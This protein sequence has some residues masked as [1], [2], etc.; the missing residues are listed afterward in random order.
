MRGPSHIFSPTPLFLLRCVHFREWIKN[1]AASSPAAAA[2]TALVSTG[3]AGSAIAADLEDLSASDK[4]SPEDQKAAE[5]E[6]IKRKL[7]AQAASKGQMGSGRLS[8]KV[9]MHLVE[10]ICV[11][12]L[13]TSPSLSLPFHRIAWR[14]SAR[15]RAR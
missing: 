2:A 11:R 5:A 4:L 12:A 14:L 10:S 6:R 7:E 8:F 1:V 13:L 9:V 15:S 3:S